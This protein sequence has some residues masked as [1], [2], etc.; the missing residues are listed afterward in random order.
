[1]SD[2]VLLQSEERLLLQGE[3]GGYLI[4]MWFNKG[5]QTI[6]SAYPVIP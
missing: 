3:G 4:R 1:L 5:T 6:E 2:T